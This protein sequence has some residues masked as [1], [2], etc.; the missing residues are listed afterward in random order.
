MRRMML[1]LAGLTLITGCETVVVTEEAARMTCSD[2]GVSDAGFDNGVSFAESDK[3]N[4]FSASQ[5]MSN[6]HGGCEGSCDDPDDDANCL[7]ECIACS[8]AIVSYVYSQD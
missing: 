1:L 7:S 3:A 6:A 2:L 8:N 5:S 4:G